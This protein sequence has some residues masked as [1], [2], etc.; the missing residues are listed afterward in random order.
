[1]AT[2]QQ[3]LVVD[4]Q[5][6][7]P[8][9]SVSASPPL[10]EAE[11]DKRIQQMEEIAKEM[12]KRHKET[13]AR[14]EE[15]RRAMLEVLN[16]E[17][18]MDR[19][20]TNYLK[21]EEDKKKAPL[22]PPSSPALRSA[23]TSY[24]TAGSLR[25]SKS[26]ANDRGGSMELQSIRRSEEREEDQEI[27][28]PTP[29]STV[30]STPSP[31]TRVSVKSK[32]EKPAR[33]EYPF[34]QCS[35]TPSPQVSEEKRCKKWVP[36]TRKR[37]PLK[38]IIEASPD[39]NVFPKKDFVKRTPLQSST[40]DPVKKLNWDPATSLHPRPVT[41]T[42]RSTTPTRVSPSPSPRRRVSVSPSPALYHPKHMGSTVQQGS[43]SKAPRRFN[44]A[45][46]LYRGAA[47]AY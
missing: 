12:H 1:M 5:A 33:V 41:P 39:S 14:N 17:E 38:T 28:L 43:F 13:G 47:S 10:G 27:I 42:K 44:P 7:S 40:L 20:L 35:V 26:I 8:L 11:I 15:L 16:Q 22:E 34:R 4:I 19:K 46:V 6:G 30:A 21:E 32:W 2:P 9:A 18:K 37:T 25:R 24:V 36:D 29:K 31:R 3:A 45:D 23:I